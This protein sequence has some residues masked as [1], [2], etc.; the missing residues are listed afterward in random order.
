[1][2]KLFCFGLGYTGMAVARRLAG[3]GWQV[4]GTTRDKDAGRPDASRRDAPRRDAPRIA[5]VEF[6][7]IRSMAD[8]AAN[9]AATTHVLTTIAP[10]A[11]GDPALAWHRADLQRH[12]AGLKRIAYLSTTA[13]Y[14]DLGGGW[15]DEATPV[16]PASTRAH[17]RVAAE[18][19]WRA[20]AGKMGVALDI[21]RLS[22]I[23]GPGR[24]QLAALRTGIAKR[25]NKPGHVFNRIHVEDIATTIGAAFARAAPGAIYNVADNE[26]A[27]PQDVVAFAADL[28]GLA[29][30][31]EIAFAEAQMSPMARSFYGESKRV[32]NRAIVEQLGVSLAYPTY[33]EGL[34]ALCQGGL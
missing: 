25:I 3:Q 17:Q 19:E 18:E 23:Y 26:P 20:L 31:P 1:M 2:N 30:P 5:C 15:V 29:P 4:C 8:F 12:G 10:G 9:F 27:P 34:R 28:L 32:S 22:G 33:R 7:G 24:N 6:T 21:F 13:V 14:G 11:K 16:A